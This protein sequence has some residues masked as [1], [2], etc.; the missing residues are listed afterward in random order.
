[1]AATIREVI[2]T[3]GR[4]QKLELEARRLTAILGGVQ[5]RTDA[6]LARL[7]ESEEPIGAA[8]R[9]QQ[10]LQKKYRAQ[11]AELK[12]HQERIAKSHEKLRAVKTNKEYQSGLKEIDDLSLIGSQLEDEMIACLDE[13]QAAQS[14]LRENQTQG[15]RR[16]AEIRMEMD[17]VR[18]EAQA[19]Q[20]RLESVKASAGEVTGRIP[21]DVLAL[22]RR[23]RDRKSDGVA[24]VEVRAAVC[25]GCHV[26]IPPQMYNELQRQDR[27]KNC[28]N[29]DR[30]IYW[31]NDE[32]RS[33]ESG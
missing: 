5:G 33:E 28:P 4:L 21:P 27:L 24:L 25:G 31:D 32:E 18:E 9:L 11:E 19:A 1:M 14:F 3:L 8:Q 22:Y 13:I 12:S 16:A 6:L 20:V 30:I 15:E 23:I 10:E 29:C 17:Q 7:R 26:N 2:R